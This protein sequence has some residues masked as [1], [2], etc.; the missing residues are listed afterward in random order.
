[1]NHF[2][3]AN[4]LAILVLCCTA[5]NKDKNSLKDISIHVMCIATT[6]KTN[7]LKTLHGCCIQHHNVNKCTI[8]G[9]LGGFYLMARFMQS[10]EAE[11]F[12][13]TLNQAW[14][15]IKFLTNSWGFDNNN[16]VTDQAFASNM[17]N[18]SRYLG[19]I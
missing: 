13:F 17:K 11:S 15:N 19:I 16:L 18:A 9:M 2:L 10:G 1:V 14:F 7:R 3:I 6:G 8:L 12:D 4:L 5:N